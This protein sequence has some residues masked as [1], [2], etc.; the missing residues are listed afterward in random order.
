MLEVNQDIICK[1]INKDRKIQ[2]QLYEYCFHL[3]MPICFKY[4]KQKEFAREM[5][6]QIFLKIIFSLDKYDLE[7]DFDK[8]AK[9][10]AINALIDE[11]RKKERVRKVMD[12]NIEIEFANSYK[13]QSVIF[14]D[15]EVAHQK[16]VVENLLKKLPPISRKVFSLFALEGFSHQ[17]IG[18]LL[19]I[20]TGTSKWH[21]SSARETLKKFVTNMFQFF[22]I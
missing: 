1:C 7:K 21:V 8:W 14:N 3:L 10:I 4:M 5:Y 15:A 12:E 11:Y 18:E 17:E 9:S 22:M 16:E 2:S 6:N 13:T 19:N 20:S